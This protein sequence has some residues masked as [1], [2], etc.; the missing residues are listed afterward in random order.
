MTLEGLGRSRPRRSPTQWRDVVYKGDDNYLSRGAPP[1]A[2]ASPGGAGHHR[3]HAT[4]TRSRVPPAG[5][6]VDAP[7]RTY[8]G[9]TLRLYVNGDEVAE[10]P[11]TGTDRIVDA[12]AR[13]R[14]RQHLRPVLRRADRRGPRLQ[15]SPAR[16]AQIQTDMATP[17][18]SGALHR[19]HSGPAAARDGR[20]ERVTR[21]SLPGSRR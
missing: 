15:P 7:R 21:R 20:R 4:P 9:A 11:Q 16:A 2:R 10:M 8:D 13:A 14:W 17:V 18:S 6:Y 3:R 19:R 1:T 12:P 5:R